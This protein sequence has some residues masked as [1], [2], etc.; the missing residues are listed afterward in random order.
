MPRVTKAELE[1]EVERLKRANDGL[2]IE[3]LTFLRQLDDERRRNRGTDDLTG[4]TSRSIDAMA[5]AVTTMSSLLKK[6]RG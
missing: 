2:R 5:Q 1:A 3:N 6:E 4:S